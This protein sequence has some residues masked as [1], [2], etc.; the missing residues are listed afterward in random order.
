MSVGTSPLNDFTRGFGTWGRTG[1][2]PTVLAAMSAALA[3]NWWLV[4]LRGG[5]AILFG[6]VALLAPFATLFTL[7]I[8]FA[9]YMLVDG[10]VGI[11]AAVRAAEKHERWGALLFAGLVDI[12]VAL[13]AVL[14][15][16]SA[17]VAFAYLL[18]AWAVVMGALTLGAA[19]QLHADHGRWWLGLSGALSLVFGAVL[20]VHPV[21]S[22]VVL[23]FWMG[24]YAIAFGAF[25]LVLAFRLRHHHTVARPSA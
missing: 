8:F 10:V 15:P 24:G 14:M 18:A 6:A 17:L 2:R 4:A 7:T 19:F 20:L 25:L 21:A 5:L 12:V 9:A 13:V 11:S 16:G 3:R 22:L 1:D 23:T